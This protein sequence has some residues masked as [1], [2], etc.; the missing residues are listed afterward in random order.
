MLLNSSILNLII[1]DFLK[2]LIF[3]PNIVNVLFN[4]KLI[5]LLRFFQLEMY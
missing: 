3:K 2:I 1:E 4:N 5:N